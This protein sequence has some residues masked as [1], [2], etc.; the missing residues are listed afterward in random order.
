MKRNENSPITLQR[1][2]RTVVIVSMLILMLVMMKE[3]K[4]C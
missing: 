4:L 2:V 1:L 3:L